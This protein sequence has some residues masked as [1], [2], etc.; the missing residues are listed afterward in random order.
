MS[1]LVVLYILLHE[2]NHYTSNHHFIATKLF[3][4]VQGAHSSGN[5]NDK[6]VEIGNLTVKY[7]N[8]SG[9][10]SRYVTFR[11]YETSRRV[12]T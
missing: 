1:Y 9:C 2:E 7:E 4:M 6:T 3:C 8:F 12:A 5:F 10:Y 11:L